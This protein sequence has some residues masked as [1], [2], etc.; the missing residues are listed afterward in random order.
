MSSSESVTFEDDEAPVW[1]DV[2]FVIVTII[3]DIY[4]AFKFTDYSLDHIDRELKEIEKNEQRRQEALRELTEDIQHDIIERQITHTQTFNDHDDFNRGHT[5]TATAVDRQHTHSKSYASHM[6]RANTGSVG[7]AGSH[8]LQTM[9][10]AQSL[11]LSAGVRTIVAPTTP[12]LRGSTPVGHNRNNLG[13]TS[14]SNIV[15]GDNAIGASSISVFSYSGGNMNQDGFGQSV[16]LAAVGMNGGNNSNSLACTSPSAGNPGNLGNSGNSPKSPKSPNSGNSG[17][18]KLPRRVHSE[19]ATITNTT[20]NTNM[21]GNSG[22][23]PSSKAA[24][25]ATGGTSISGVEVEVGNDANEAKLR[26]QPSNVSVTENENDEND[27]DDNDNGTEI[28]T[29]DND[30]E[31]N[32]NNN[33]NNK[34]GKKHN[35]VLSDKH[36]ELQNISLPTDKNGRLRSDSE[37]Q[38]HAHYMSAPERADSHFAPSPL[39]SPVAVHHVKSIE[40]S[41][42]KEELLQKLQKVKQGGT[43]TVEFV[44]LARP[45]TGLPNKRCCCILPWTHVLFTWSRTKSIRMFLRLFILLSCCLAFVLWI[46]LF[47]SSLLEVSH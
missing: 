25:L 36:Q 27:D 21:N 29:S 4:Y 16:T 28:I 37:S 34:N 31:D 33:D 23:I 8:H 38:H 18:T 1:V 2:L 7:G 12:V 35:R 26:M 43:I 9:N 14:N 39:T 46:E 13:N 45:L 15:C 30:V 11:I 6:H 41:T 3:I 5:I 32:D 44:T 20:T 42:Q 40:S 24:A 47:A 22:D 17:Q 10:T 19:S